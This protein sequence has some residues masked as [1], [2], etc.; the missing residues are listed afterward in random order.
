VARG[1][2]ASVSINH[3]MDWRFTFGGYGGAVTGVWSLPRDRVI[4]SG[5][6]L[7]PSRDTGVSG[8][9]ST[10]TEGPIREA[11]RRYR[12]G[13]W[14][15]CPSPGDDLITALRQPGRCSRFAYSYQL[16]AT[17][18]SEVPEGMA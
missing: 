12:R 10:P 14:T 4:S 5:E 8:P 13:F 3:S 9:S 11:A 16:Q 17:Y 7:R 6:H 1:S 15:G 2:G 18:C